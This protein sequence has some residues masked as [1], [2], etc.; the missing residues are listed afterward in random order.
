MA[1]IKA[2]RAEAARKRELKKNRIVEV[3]N[4]IA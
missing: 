4:A 1:R 3:R 2:M